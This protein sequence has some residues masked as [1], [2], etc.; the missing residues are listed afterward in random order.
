MSREEE[1]HTFDT[2]VGSGDEQEDEPQIELVDE[3]YIPTLSALWRFSDIASKFSGPESKVL[4]DSTRDFVKNLIRYVHVETLNPTVP[5]PPMMIVYHGVEPSVEDNLSPKE[6]LRNVSD[7]AKYLVW[8]LSATSEQGVVSMVRT[9]GAEC[10]SENLVIMLSELIHP[11]FITNEGACAIDDLCTQTFTSLETERVRI[12]RAFGSGLTSSSSAG[13]RL[14][15]A[16]G[17]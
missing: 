8:R 2:A 15:S 16:M 7:K 4:K 17:F 1:K 12:P 9:A 10:W 3:S 13:S 14:P 5:I 6:H 11:S